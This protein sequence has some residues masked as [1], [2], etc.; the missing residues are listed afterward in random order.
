MNE[1]MNLYLLSLAQEQWQLYKVHHEQD[2]KAQ[3]MVLTAT[4]DN[5][6]TNNTVDF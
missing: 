3:R 1:W 2:S 5:T 4:L 6:N